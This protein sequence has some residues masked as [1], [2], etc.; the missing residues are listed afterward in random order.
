VQV[1][2]KKL[3]R[4]RRKGPLSLSDDQSQKSKAH[5]QKSFLVP[6]TDMT[7]YLGLH[8]VNPSAAKMAFIIDGSY[9]LVIIEGSRSQWPRG[10]RQ[11]LRPLT[12]WDFGFGCCRGYGHP[13]LV[14]VV[15]CQV[16]VSTSG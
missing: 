14:S 2:K 5:C 7:E 12:G 4:Q 16:E 15:S 11:D 6:S 1:C 3:V 13:S 10:L 8:T 9:L